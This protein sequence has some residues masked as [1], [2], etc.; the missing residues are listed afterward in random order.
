[1]RPDQM[2]RISVDHGTTC[3][4]PFTVAEDTAQRTAVYPAGRP[5]NSL[6]LYLSAAE[7]AALDARQIAVGLLGSQAVMIKYRPAH[8]PL[9]P[10]LVS[11]HLQSHWEKLFVVNIEVDE[12]CFV[13]PNQAG[14]DCRL[15]YIDADELALFNAGEP[16]P[17]VFDWEN[18][19]VKRA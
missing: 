19:F 16:A 5:D 4:R 15:L 17:C 2:L 11:D 10:I 14:S 18:A 12:I 8:L 6:P 1:M 9:G 7:R 13:S 3:W